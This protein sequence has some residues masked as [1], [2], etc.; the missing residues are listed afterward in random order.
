[1]HNNFTGPCVEIM[2]ENEVLASWFRKVKRITPQI[3]LSTKMEFMQICTG[4]C[5][6]LMSENE[7][8]ASWRVRKGTRQDISTAAIDNPTS[9]GSVL[10]L[11]CSVPSPVH[12][13]NAWSQHT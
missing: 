12:K 4:P 10:V 13:S 3:S 11:A 8:V 2:S 7:V 9:S 5:L 6:E 1:M